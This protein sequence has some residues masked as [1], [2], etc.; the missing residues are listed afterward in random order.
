L[1]LDAEEMK[2]IP[3]PSTWALF[4]MGI[5]MLMISVKKGWEK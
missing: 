1:D 2:P 3:E 4:L 5:L